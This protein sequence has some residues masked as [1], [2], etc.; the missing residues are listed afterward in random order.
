MISIAQFAQLI[1][2]LWNIKELG[3]WPVIIVAMDQH[4]VAPSAPESRVL[5]IMT[6]YVPF[7]SAFRFEPHLASQD[8][9]HA[10]GPGKDLL[11]HWGVLG[12]VSKVDRDGVRGYADSEAEELS[13]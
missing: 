12:F 6:G 2:R 11:P 7:R 1:V 8:I 13:V 9:R 10:S 3:L 5:V 4:S